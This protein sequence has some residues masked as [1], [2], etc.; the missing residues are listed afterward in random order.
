[1]NFKKH[2]LPVLLIPIFG[3]ADALNQP[4][5]LPKRER[6]VFAEQK[7]PSLEYVKSLETAPFPVY[8]V[9]TW[10]G[11]F[12]QLREQIQAVGYKTL[13]VGGNYSDG[14]IKALFD[15]G[16]NFSL[17][18]QGGEGK[19]DAFETDEAYIEASLKGLSELLDRIGENGSFYEIHPEHKGRF[20]P[21]MQLRNEPNFHYMYQAGTEAER[22]KLYAALAPKLLELIREKSPKT[23]VIGFSA[24]GAGAGDMRF[25]RS[26]L[27]QSPE[28]IAKLD[29]ISTHPYVHPAPPE[30]NKKEKWG[31]FSQ[32]NSL[33]VLRNNFAEYD[34]RT[35]PVWYT[36]GGWTISA[37]EG[38]AYK[39][40]AANVPLM[41]HAAYS[42]R[43][44]AWALRLGVQCVTT[45]FITDTDGHAGGHFDRLNKMAWRPTA[46]AIQT[47]IR[48]M[49]H[50][51][52]DGVQSDGEDLNYIYEFK[53]DALDPESP[54]VIMAYRI[55]GAKEVEIRVPFASA[56]VTDMLGDTRPLNIVNGKVTVEIGPFPVYVH[57][58]E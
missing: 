40:N 5:G 14:N 52:L 29:V 48:L 27:K 38:G 7:L 30:L 6:V 51:K 55:E 50:P 47:M 41:H 10:M 57:D 25:V 54:V 4:E 28:Y 19:R 1:M 46:H 36:E 11:E 18:A 17:M 9:Y 42:V 26:V 49:P 15:S 32:A 8:G 3:A 24:G 31:S 23:K 12:M 21:Y 20:V 2:V 53:R 58:A 16:L 37:E 45:M 33:H 44:Y 13:R 39:S 22:E 35:I 43:Y 56:A 34:R